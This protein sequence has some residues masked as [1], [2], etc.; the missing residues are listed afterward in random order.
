MTSS[1]E[2][3]NTSSIQKKMTSGQFDQ[4]L[5]ELQQLLDQD[6]NHADAHYMSAVCCRYQKNYLQAQKHIDALSELAL[7]RGR[8]YQEQGHLYRAQLF[9]D[10]ALVAYQAACQLNPALIASWQA[11]AELLAGVGDAAGAH[12]RKFS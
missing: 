6:P 10:R 1:T 8:L 11:Q 3:S 2:A 9:V 4:A 12:Q 5:G 7:D